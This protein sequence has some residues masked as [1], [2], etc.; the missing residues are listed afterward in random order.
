MHLKLAAPWPGRTTR[1][2]GCQARTTVLLLVLLLGGCAAAPT[3]TELTA[4]AIQFANVEGAPPASDGRAR[5]RATF[6]ASL[7]ADGVVPDDDLTCARWLWR[8]PD[9]PAAAAPDREATDPG[10]RRPAY[11]NAAVF[12]V[13]GAFSECVGEA[14]RPFIAGV[15]RLRE[16][17]AR[18][19][20][21]VVSGRSGTGNNARQIAA[22]IEQAQL[23]NDQ[24]ILMVGY[25]KGSLDILRFLVDFPEFS[26]R[27]DAVVSVGGPIF[28]TPLADA[29]DSAYSTL[30]ARL[31]YEK[32]PPG[33]GQ[34]IHSLKPETAQGWLAENPLPANVRY[35]SL[36]AFTT[37]KH[38][39]RSLVPTWKYL[40]RFD[41]RNDGQVIAA[42]ALIPGATLL[43]FAN[44]DHWGV[45]ESIEK[46]HPF[47][48]GRPDPRPFPLEQLF[49]SI[50]RF[51]LDDPAAGATPG[52]VNSSATDEVDG[53]LE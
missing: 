52:A 13:T 19:E 45:A 28:G 35:Y 32:C 6:C 26:S 1:C 38:M 25:S 24:R 7:R 29:V 47:M 17:G 10:S 3:A 5:F 8:L 53:R 43:G 51:V 27:V 23:A 49:L 48:A 44:A 11:T 41:V 2:A 39:A 18:V 36:A 15:A 12:V 4:T 31:P 42:D 33:D 21:I 16:T 40:N 9:E 34:V 50:V 46:V 14:G 22:A 37:R 30:V 20:T